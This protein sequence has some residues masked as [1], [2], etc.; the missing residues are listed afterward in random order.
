LQKEPFDILVIG[1][2]ITGAGIARDAAMR[3]FKTALIEKA[4]FCSGTS[5]KTSKLIHGGFRYLENFEF[6]LVREALMERKILMDIAPHLVHSIQ[7][8]LPFHNHTS[9]SPWMVHAGLLMYDLLSFTKR[10]S[11]HKMLSIKNIPKIEPSLRREGLKK[12]ARYYDCQADDFRL[13]MANLQSAAQNSAVITNYVKAADIL[14]ENGEIIGIKA[15][16]EI[17]GESFPI[18]SNT[19]ANATGPWCNYLRQTLLNDSQPCVRT[20]K[21]IH[22]VIHRKNLPINYTILGQA[23]QD[24]RFIFAVPWKQ[25]VFLGTTDTDYDSDP[26]R[27]PTE[28]QEV[29]YLLEAFN[30][31]F[32]NVNL[33]YKNIISTY[34]GLRPLT[35]D[36]KKTTSSVTREY[37]IFEQ[38]Q[39]FFNIVGGKL[40]TYRTMAKEMINRISKRLEKTFNISPKNSKCMTDIIPLY[41]GDISDY[42]KFFEDWKIRLIK[43][44]HLDP[45]IA[46]HLIE[47]YGSHLPEMLNYIK[48]SSKRFLPGLPYIWGELDY[49]LEHEMAMALDDFLIRRTHLFSLDSKHGFYLHEEIASRLAQKLGW[50]NEEKR[51]QIEGYKAKIEITQHYLKSK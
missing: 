26:D 49:A 6:S 27:I 45:D 4:D 44:N 24:R 12:I 29:D 36:E 34:A 16:N 50:S 3:G 40:T 47:T 25:F 13:T 39:N 30:Y 51:K 48:K 38:P 7:C 5:S 23:I 8:L 42:P 18:R 31:Y 28:H 37:Q 22:L 2:G 33:K 35:F 43:Q 15:Q 21:G 46:E 1:G 11:F 9:M 14:Q 10:I 19:I 32:P 17:N 41:G 20:T